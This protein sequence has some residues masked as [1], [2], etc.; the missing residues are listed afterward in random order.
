V[1]SETAHGAQTA[2]HVNWQT[3]GRDTVGAE[4]CRE[5]TGYRAARRSIVGS[6]SGLRA[7]SRRGC[8]EAGGWRRPA[9]G[10]APPRPWGLFV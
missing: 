8:S 6:S 5:L 9:R 7:A 1:S 10:G 3:E 4:G 2:P